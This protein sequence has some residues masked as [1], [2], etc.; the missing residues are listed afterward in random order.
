MPSRLS[1]I[2]RHLARSTTSSVWSGVFSIADD[3]PARSLT[4]Q[5]IDIWEHAAL[6]YHGYEW[7]DA[8]DA[9]RSLVS[10]LDGEHRTL[11]ALNA[12]IIQSRLG[13]Y[14]EA[15]QTLE[16]A[17]TYNQNYVLIPFLLALVEWD[18]GNLTK[19]KACFD[20]CLES[21]RRS[22]NVDYRAQG[23]D[24][25]LTADYVHQLSGHL[26]ETGY[27][28][29]GTA[30]RGIV[31]I[32]PSVLPAECIFEAPPRPGTISRSSFSEDVGAADSDKIRDSKFSRAKRT[33]DSR[34]RDS[35]TSAETL[36]GGPSIPLQPLAK[37]RP[38]PDPFP[39]R[40]S[41]LS[42]ASRPDPAPKPD[43]PLPVKYIWPTP[44]SQ[45]A[46]GKPIAVV[47]TSLGR[48]IPVA[49]APRFVTFN[50]TS[51]ETAREARP[52]PLHRRKPSLSTLRGPESPK[53][54]QRVSVVG[55]QTT[56]PKFEKLLTETWIERAA[57]RL[58]EGKLRKPNE[59]PK[60]NLTPS[61]K[62]FRSKASRRPFFRS[63]RAMVSLP[64]ASSGNVSV[65]SLPP[66]QTKHIP[67]DP[68]GE[69]GDIMS[70]VAFVREHDH[71][72][73]L[74]LLLRPPRGGPRKVPPSKELAEF[75]Q[76]AAR[77]R[78]CVDNAGAF[79]YNIAREDLLI[80]APM[81]WANK[82]TREILEA[83][84]RH[85]APRLH[86]PASRSRASRH[87]HVESRAQAVLAAIRY[88]RYDNDHEMDED[89]DIV[90]QILE[91]YHASPHQ[92]HH[93]HNQ[94]LP[95]PS[96]PSPSSSRHSIQL[97]DGEITPTFH[98]P[99][100]HI[101]TAAS[102][103]SS[104]F[105]G[106]LMSVERTERARDAAMRMLEGRRRA[107]L[108]PCRRRGEGEREG[109]GSGSGNGDRGY[110]EEGEEKALPRCPGDGNSGEGKERLETRLEEMGQ[111]P[112]RMPSG[113]IFAFMRRH[114]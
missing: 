52:P 23:L 14:L 7:Q 53:S 76:S 26:R 49:D 55:K 22:G 36:Q 59:R 64:T 58:A 35:R 30:K 27:D 73:P 88:E 5:D 62:S 81:P 85:S 48:W 1:S 12:S 94:K 50:K 3:E 102:S 72:A 96:P 40:V 78:L 103:S 66:Q 106:S 32:V 97:L 75:L 67:R 87:P 39:A 90:E 41:S 92:H 4:A 31:H 109:E 6:L 46:G 16:A 11:C 108:L 98:N 60:E 80:G 2:R 34:Q 107:T 51:N 42:N 101:H 37:P 38:I 20:G 105:A 33:S 84:K 54:V 113:Q 65:A 25:V 43:V 17:A 28:R 47:Q 110:G 74:E 91:L 93:N 86:D 100:R 24:F 70:I 18:L 44:D 111:A 89:D 10:R 19:T 8:I 69:Y 95:Q 61:N 83:G 82:A 99:Y 9:F 112:L 29:Y 56:N 21:L 104:L 63:R 45:D 77:D 68:R 15:R 114:G 57:R 79:S 71:Q 13:D